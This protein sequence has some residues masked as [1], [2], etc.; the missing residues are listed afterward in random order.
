MLSYDVVLSEDE[1]LA[2][3]GMTDSEDEVVASW[4]P[5]AGVLVDEKAAGPDP[6]LEDADV[7]EGAGSAPA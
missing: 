3:M 2:A 6:V 5:A 4:Y 1:V 7:L